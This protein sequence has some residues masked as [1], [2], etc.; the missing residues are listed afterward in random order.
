MGFFSFDSRGISRRLGPR[1][2]SRTDRL[3]LARHGRDRRGQRVAAESVEQL[4]ARHL[5]AFDLVAAYAQSVTPFYVAGSNS[6]AV[7]LDEAAGLATRQMAHFLAD[8]AGL[9]LADAIDLMSIAGELQICQVV[10]PL[11]TCRFSLPRAVAATLGIT[12][13]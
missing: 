6:A 3:R 4:E 10:D 12:L 8:V 7:T 9:S 2:R 1:D 11:K 5:L 13:E